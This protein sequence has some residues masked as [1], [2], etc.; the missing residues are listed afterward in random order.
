MSRA[1]GPT[2][3]TAAAVMAILERQKFR[4]A[5]SGR[6]LT[7]QSASID[8]IAPIAKGGKHEMTNLWVVENTI[9]RAKNTMTHDEFLA[10]CRDVVRFADGQSASEVA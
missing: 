5:L 7:P 2:V 1:K 10:M 3:V 8:H 9:N 4:C 6:P